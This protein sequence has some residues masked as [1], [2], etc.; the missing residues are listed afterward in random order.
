MEN[1]ISNAES[2]GFFF[3][4]EYINHLKSLPKL[5]S[6]ESLK[7][8]LLDTDIRREPHPQTSFFPSNSNNSNFHGKVIIRDSASSSSSS[9]S[10]NEE[11]IYLRRP[12]VLQVTSLSNITLPPKRKLEES[13]PRMLSIGLTDGKTRLTG[14]EFSKI[15]NI[16][17]NMAPGFKVLYSGGEIV[18]GKLILNESN[19]KFLGGV[20]SYLVEAHQANLTVQK[21][22]SLFKGITS[23]SGSKKSNNNS[24]VLCVTSPPKFQFE[25]L[26]EL[27]KNEKSDNKHFHRSSSASLSTPSIAASSSTKSIQS[28][29]SLSQKSKETTSKNA[30]PAN[31]K[32]RKNLKPQ[33]QAQTQAPS[34]ETK[35]KNAKEIKNKGENTHVQPPSGSRETKP[36]SH[37]QAQT[38]TQAPPSETKNKNARENKNKVELTHPQVSSNQRERENKK[39]KQTKDERN[40]PQP[41]IS[42]ETS[43]R[44][45]IPSNSKANKN[46]KENKIENV[47][48]LQPSH[49]TPSISSSQQNNNIT[50]GNKHEKSTPL[51]IPPNNIPSQVQKNNQ[52][53]IKQRNNRNF[54]P[55]SSTTDSN[56][57]VPPHIKQTKDQPNVASQ[58][59]SQNN[60]KKS[61][62]DTSLPPSSA[63]SSTSAS[64]TKE[65][66]N[67]NKIANQNKNQPHDEKNEKNIKQ[68][69]ENKKELK[70]PPP[71]HSPPSSTSASSSSNPQPPSKSEN[72]GNNKKNNNNNDSIL[73]PPSPPVSSQSQ[74][75]KKYKD[76][77]NS[78]PNANTQERKYIEKRPRGSPRPPSF[79]AKPPSEVPL[80]VAQHLNKKKNEEKKEQN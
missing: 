13:Y 3:T 31:T 32:E 57:V 25:L 24:S 7:K 44:A 48:T 19:C 2:F 79:Q 8:E 78:T 21:Y 51:I 35:N 23:T 80:V 47:S 6:F 22:R 9:S 67:K 4:E 49:S 68:K 61:K 74:P 41:Q 16:K 12:I 40:V 71:V 34:S 65:N 69:Q 55:D 66:K 45:P 70:N 14:I 53:E 20:V 72:R 75:S 50:K 77:S 37:P 54:G 62:S 59:L 15:P 5:P 46:P 26:E 18:R 52:R 29:K 10:S 42:S 30:P 11:I 28:S 38:Q 33:T 63:P 39:S 36:R 60:E 76:S 1:L 56:L 17:A 64:T 43:P 73:L 58:K 27:S